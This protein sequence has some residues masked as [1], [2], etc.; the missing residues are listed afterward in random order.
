[1]KSPTRNYKGMTIYV[2]CDDKRK[3]ILTIDQYNQIMFYD[4]P[5]NAV[6]DLEAINMFIA[7]LEQTQQEEWDEWELYEMSQ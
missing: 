7:Q 3:S 6:T 5:E 4:Y 2:H 1:M